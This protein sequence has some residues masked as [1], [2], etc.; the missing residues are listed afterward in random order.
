MNKH[1]NE[2]RLME[3]F[4]YRMDEIEHYHR[5]FRDFGPGDTVTAETYAIIMRTQIEDLL[6]LMR[7]G[8]VKITFESR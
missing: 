6:Y 2:K 3:K 1:D 7:G 5:R 8:K 4:C